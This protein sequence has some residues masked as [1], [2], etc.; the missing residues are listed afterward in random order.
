M[1]LFVLSRAKGPLLL[2]GPEAIMYFLRLVAEQK[3]H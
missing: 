2:F 3:D 1:T